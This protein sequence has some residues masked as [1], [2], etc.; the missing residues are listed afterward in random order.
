MNRMSATITANMPEWLKEAVKRKAQAE[1]LSI[2][3][4]VRKALALYVTGTLEE[5]TDA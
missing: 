5:P 3:A 2:S 1:Q 4:L